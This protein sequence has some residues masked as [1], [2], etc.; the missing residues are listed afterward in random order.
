MA[1][2][3]II[4]GIGSINTMGF[5]IF[6]IPISQELGLSRAV[7]SL[8]PSISRLE[9]GLLGPSAGWLIDRVGSRRML[10]IGSVLGGAGLIL[11]G[12]LVHS[13]WTL[14]LV[15]LLLIGVGFNMGF[16]PGT[17]AAIN[18]W[19]I[20]RRTLAMSIVNAAWG[21]AAFILV[22][23]LSFLTLH[24][25]WRTAAVVAGCI[26]LSTAIPAVLV[27][28]RSPES[29]GL[30]PDGREADADQGVPVSGQVDGVIRVRSAGAD[31][32]VK[33][34]LA[35][36]AFWLLLIAANLRNVTYSPILVHFAPLL[37]SKGLS[38]QS[39]AWLIGLWSLLVIPCSLGIGILGDRLNK[40]VLL[41]SIILSAAA[42]YLLLAS[43]E[44]WWLV[45]LL[46]PLLAPFD[47]LGVL[48]SSLLAEMFGRRNFATLRGIITGVGSLGSA[49]SP[50]FMGWVFDQTQSYTWAL[51]PFGVAL[52]VSAIMYAVLPKV[53]TR[54]LV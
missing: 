12:L 25:G 6:F 52:L 35:T 34:A 27:I 48:Y 41:S 29:M 53:T 47:N 38:Q 40:R 23:L 39:A 5:T 33:E 30:L 17:I 13:L 45:Y 3:S 50:V 49:A 24:Y 11:L 32:T 16:F 51:V 1:A 14:F 21:G 15:Y 22:P 2:G 7:L 26:V 4:A 19:F 9:G 8:V 18:T 42:V 37:V 20:R 54:H 28:R 36:P 46:I 31:Y 43:V 44:Y 10:A